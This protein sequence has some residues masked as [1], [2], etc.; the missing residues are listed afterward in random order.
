MQRNYSMT[1][2]MG[3]K[4]EV[5]IPGPSLAAKANALYSDNASAGWTYEDCLAMCA[6]ASLN[7]L[8]VV[9]LETAM[10]MDIKDYLAMRQVVVSLVAPSAQQLQNTIDSLLLLDSSD[11][12]SN[13]AT[14][15]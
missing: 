6:L 8:P 1:L 10:A 9:D 12:I 13:A 4:V 15:I 7:G 3:T 11:G 5:S 2:P 14:A